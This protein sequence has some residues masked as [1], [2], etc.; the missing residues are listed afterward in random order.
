MSRV[1]VSV[2]LLLIAPVLALYAIGHGVCS[3]VASI[4]EALCEVWQ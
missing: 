4:A 1:L 2:I 3:V